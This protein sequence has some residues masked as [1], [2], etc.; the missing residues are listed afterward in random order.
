MIIK[1][2]RFDF[3]EDVGNLLS[4]F[5]QEHSSEK[6]GNFQHSWKLWVDEPE[7]KKTLENEDIRLQHLGFQGDVWDKMYKSARYYYKKKQHQKK[8]S[9]KLSN[10]HTHRFSNML[11]EKIDVWLQ[12]E[13]KKNIVNTSE[14]TLSQPESY[15][16]FCL[17]QKNVLLNEFTNIKKNK[18][19]IPEDIGQKLKKTYKNRFHNIRNKIVEK[20]I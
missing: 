8:L 7:V 12:G 15:N 18:G 19:I 10:K 1:K 11:L 6:C 17:L 4:K 14:I 20:T 9:P 13:F 16:R 2:F 3:T 5:S